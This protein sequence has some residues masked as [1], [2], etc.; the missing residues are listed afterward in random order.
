MSVKASSTSL[1]SSSPSLTGHSVPDSSPD[2]A[3]PH[4]SLVSKR[5]DVPSAPYMPDPESVPLNPLPDP[6][7]DDASPSGT[8]NNDHE[9][10]G[11]TD[12]RSE[13]GVGIMDS[14]TL[15]PAD[16]ESEES[17][18]DADEGRVRPTMRYLSAPLSDGR[19]SLSRHS[20][21]NVPVSV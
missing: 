1:S 4:I 11:S 10:S 20:S 19:V 7:L 21:R 5:N 15:V 2:T 14:I 12:T 17:G 8:E 13:S 16:E 18:Q 3:I 9:A 6:V